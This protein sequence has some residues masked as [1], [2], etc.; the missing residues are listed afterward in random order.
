[1]ARGGEIAGVWHEN[2]AP[3]LVEHLLDAPQPNLQPPKGRHHGNLSERQHV[4][5]QAV[6]NPARQ[7][8]K[9]EV[10]GEEEGGGDLEGVAEA[11]PEDA[12]EG[13][14]ARR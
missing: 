4:S 7:G 1:M 13:A 12:V 6:R 8:R 5:G 11:A 9:V 2:L 3:P 10:V 14:G